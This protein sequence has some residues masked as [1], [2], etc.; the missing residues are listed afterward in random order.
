MTA[1]LEAA[2]RW[3]GDWKPE[4]A[5]VLGSGLAGLA[6]QLEHSSRLPYQRIPGFELP[7]VEGHRGE[8]IAGSIGGKRVLVQGGRFHGYEGHSPET[9]VRPVRLFAGLG[10]GTL[11]LTN[12]AGGIGAGLGPGSIM[13]ISD[14]LNFTFSNPLV[15]PLHPGDLRF[16][17]LSQ[18]YDLELRRLARA[19][20]REQGVELKEGTYGG[21]MG[22]S[23]E[24]R[25]EVVML[26][27]LGAD[28]VG[29]ST[30]AEVLAARAAGIRCLA[31]SL[32]TNRAAGLG[33]GVLS[34]AEVMREAQAA[35]ARLGQLMARVIARI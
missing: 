24:S 5:L 27:R 23:Y 16:P 31:F 11:I 22:P 20:A 12:A 19:V 17:D 6:D 26:R 13:L 15:G 18:P 7:G 35:G 33:S 4:V 25:A 2:G 1:T 34:H 29:M 14:H 8:L 30:V 3:L 9:V 21:V 32:I 28:A 10:V